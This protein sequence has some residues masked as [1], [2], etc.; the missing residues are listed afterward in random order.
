MEYDFYG[1]FIS[2]IVSLILTIIIESC[3]I[4][5]LILW[6]KMDYSDLFNLLLINC[7]TNPVVVTFAN[8]LWL[9][10]GRYDR[11]ALFSCL[12]FIEI[13]VVFI[14]GWLLKKLNPKLGKKA[15][16]IAFCLNFVSYFCSFLIM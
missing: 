9:L 16:L 3:L 8:F 12:S 14:E 1:F 13:L 7:L 2:L 4:L 10:F 5:P 6:K 11:N 15:Y